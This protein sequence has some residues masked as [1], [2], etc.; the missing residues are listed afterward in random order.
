MAVK[1]TNFG[2]LI[3]M[4]GKEP[5]YRYTPKGTP[6]ATFS[7]AVDEWMRGDDGKWKKTT[8][9]FNL[10][11]FGNLADQVKDS[12]QK[13]SLVLVEF[14]LK[15]RKYERDGKTFYENDIRLQS[16]KALSNRKPYAKG[17]EGGD[18]EEDQS[19]G[20]EDFGDIPF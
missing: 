4:V 7:L 20:S 13:G 11:A 18:F 19:E 14:K 5:E 3:G 12:V 1:T 17:E 9:W 16:I 6:M 15:R 10:A 2:S 8:D